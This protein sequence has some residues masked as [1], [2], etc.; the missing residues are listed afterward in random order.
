MD[1]S[2]LNGA[3]ATFILDLYD[4]FRK[5]PA[6]IDPSWAAFFRDLADDEAALLH[7]LSGASWSEPGALNGEDIFTPQL[8]VKA[9]GKGKGAKER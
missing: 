6:A 2:F 1:G 7:E 3:N 9:D 5:D 4:R 8:A